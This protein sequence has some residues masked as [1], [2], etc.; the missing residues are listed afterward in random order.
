L[1]IDLIGSSIPFEV[2]MFAA[3]SMITVLFI[4]A[5][6]TLCTVGVTIWL[7]A[8]LDI[9]AEP[10][11]GRVLQTLAA[12]LLVIGASRI[13]PTR[14]SSHAGAGL[15]N[16]AQALRDYCASII[17]RD[18]T[19]RD[20]T[21]ASMLAASLKATTLVEESG[22]EPGRHLIH[23]DY[24]LQID[25]DLRAATAIAASFDELEEIQPSA[26]LAS[27]QSQITERSLADLDDLAARLSAVQASGVVTFVG[28]E[29]PGATTAFERLVNKADQQ[30]DELA[31]YRQSLAKR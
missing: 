1:L 27:G 31:L 7:M 19:E 10:T 29:R 24:A 22:H 21:R 8:V 11:G 13:W 4:V 9:G 18:R 25:E 17:A 5:N 16:L 28:G 6:Y 15:A 26:Q 3:G 14:T 30:L 2:A 23:Y 12:G 20:Q